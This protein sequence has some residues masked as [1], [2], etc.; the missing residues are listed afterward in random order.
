[1][2]YLKRKSETLYNERESSKEEIL[3]LEELTCSD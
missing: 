3:K 1:M 2:L